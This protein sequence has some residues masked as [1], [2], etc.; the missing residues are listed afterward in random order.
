M[1]HHFLNHQRCMVSAYPQEK[2]L[3]NKIVNHLKQDTSIKKHI[4]KNAIWKSDLLAIDTIYC[5]PESEKDVE[6]IINSLQ[7][8]GVVT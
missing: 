1:F 7:G 2:V 6:G 4:P 3:A 8:A 5:T